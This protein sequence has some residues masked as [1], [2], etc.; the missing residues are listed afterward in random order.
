MCSQGVFNYHKVA[1]DI[2]RICQTSNGNSLIG[3]LV[4]GPTV[5]Q[6]LFSILIRFWLHKVALSGDIA[7]IYRQI[8]LD[9]AAKDFTLLWRDSN[10][11]FIK[12]FRMTR[13]TYGI[14]FSAFHS[15][16]SV[17]EVAHLCKDQALAQSINYFY[18]DDYLSGA[19]SVEDAKTKV[20]YHCAVLNNYGFELRK[21][22]SSHHEI[23]LSLPESLREST[24][25]E[26]FMDNNYK[27][28]TLAVSWKPNSDHFSFDANLTVQGNVTKRQLLSETAK[29]F[30]PVGWLSPI[31]IR[32]KVLLQ[33][34]WVQG[35]E[36]DQLVSTAIQ[37]EW[38]QIKDDLP[39]LSE[40][41]LQRC[42]DLKGKSRVLD[43]I[44]FQ[45]P[46]K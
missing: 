12:Q 3:S 43:F 19:E 41:K 33:K 13:F 23:T 42:I 17:V 26:K 39:H 29:L 28:Q 1:C 31:V 37:E 30:D 18:V 32:S 46:L 35:I 11:D 25:H 8:A 34:L 15:T 45:M 4:V 5:K 44:C 21:W 24:N 36:W 16:R 9:P 10:T 40:L 14:A 6:D 20:N 27:R 7:K 38:E 2:R 22:A